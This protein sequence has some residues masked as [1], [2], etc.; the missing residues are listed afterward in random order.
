MSNKLNSPEIRFTSPTITGLEKEFIEDAITNRTLAGGGK[1]YQKCVELIKSITDAKYA[2]VTNSGTSALEMAALV[3]N[4]QEGDEIIMPSYTFTSTA[5]AFMIFGAKIKFVD[6][7]SDTCNIDE[8]LIKQAITN[9]TKAI[10]VVDYG[11][12]AVEYDD[13][14]KIAKQ[15]KIPVIADSAQSICAFYKNRPLGSIADMTAFSFHETKNIT[16]GGEGGAFVTNNKSY[17]SLANVIVEKGTNRIEFLN[18]QVD[19]YTWVNRGS[20]YLPAEINA[21]YLYPSLFNVKRIT[22]HRLSL[23]EQYYK[24]LE[25]L[26][27]SGHLTLPIIPSNC[28]HNGHIFYIKLV[29]YEMRISLAKYLRDHNIYASFHY[30]P[31]HSTEYGLSQTQFIGKDNYTTQTYHRLLRLP[32]HNEMHLSDVDL[33]CQKI[34]DFFNCENK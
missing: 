32:I 27:K 33:V 20:S 9:K 14:I 29:N 11:S 7:R 5:N 22:D 31:L 16:A 30:V 24:K 10:V 4:I 6:I 2:I 13:I 25:G 1:Y 18:G 26:A 28:Q 34:T 15:Y 12:V 19:K 8:N 23:W 3:L 17:I 21:A